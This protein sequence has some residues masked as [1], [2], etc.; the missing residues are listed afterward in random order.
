MDLNQLLK[1]DFAELGM[2]ERFVEQSKKMSFQNLED[3]L[4]CQPRE[5]FE[6]DGFNYLWLEELI[7]LL[8]SKELLHLLQPRPGKNAS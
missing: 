7:R 6:R 8:K 3:V 2:S 4:I 5:L 1:A